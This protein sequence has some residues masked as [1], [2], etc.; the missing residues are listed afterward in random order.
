MFGGGGG[1]PSVPQPVPTVPVK[2]SAT[3]AAERAKQAALM[4]RRKG[5]AAT[6]LGGETQ[7][8]LDTQQKE[9]LGA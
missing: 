5:R 3:I 4:Q 7:T 1:V 2:D 8:V 6:I 9:L